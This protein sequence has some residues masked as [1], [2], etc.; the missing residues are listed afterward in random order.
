MSLLRLVPGVRYE[1]DIEAMGESFGS[2]VPNIGGQR[3][4]WN[5]VM[6]DGLLGNE[7]SG[8]NRF[9]SAINLD[10]IA[11]VKVLLNTYQAEYGRSG[12]ANVQIVS[13]SGGTDYHGSAY[14]YARRDQ[15]NSNRWENNRAGLPKPEYHF[16]TYGFNL[17]GPAAFPGCGS[18]MATRSSSSST[19]WK[20]RRCRIRVRSGDTSCRPSGKGG[21]ISRR[22]SIS[23]DVSSSSAIRRTRG[24]PFS[25]NV[26]PQNRINPN[27]LA[28]VNALPL[29]NTDGSRGQSNFQR[30][31][32]PDNPRW[33]NVLR[34][35]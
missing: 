16:D 27:T 24:Q 11:E 12:G 22:P 26:I 4:H 33:N 6:V 10:A 13:K 8:T 3:R 2:L 21:A 5:T 23:R 20:R 35:D 25:G 9:S 34:M 28:L 18:R 14:Y 1:G 29:P 30:Q 15:W 31:E 7:T 19:P 32:T 17:G